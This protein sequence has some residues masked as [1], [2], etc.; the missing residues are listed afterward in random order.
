VARISDLPLSLRL[1]LRAYRWRRIDP[2]PSAPLNKPLREAKVAI[3]S[4]AGLVLP[5][6]ERFDMEVKGG[7]W[8]WREVPF[9]AD[10]TTFIDAHRSDSYDHGGVHADANLAFPL[11][12][13]RELAE[14]GVV[15]EV[16]HR[17]FS[18]MGS[19][20]APGRLMADSAPRVA[21]ALEEDAVDA[22]LLVPI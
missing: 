19:I 14:E 20:T 21:A 10:A 2:V 17:H 22:V 16:N 9:D 15:G 7:D 3:V 6:Q 11:D 1:F 8:S 5:G 4:T 12:R 13:L 18:F